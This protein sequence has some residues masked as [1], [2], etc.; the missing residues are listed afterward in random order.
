MGQ[1]MKF[2]PVYFTIVQ[3]RFNPILS[4]DSYAP[5]IQE[6]LRKAGFPDFQKAMK[7]TLNIPAAGLQPDQSVSQGPLSQTLLYVFGDMERTSIFLLEPGALSFQTT[8]YDVFETLLSSFRKGLEAVEEAV[9]LSYTD[10]IGLRYLDAVFPKTGETLRD[11]ICPGLLGLA[12]GFQ[13]DGLTY[14]FS[15]NL[16]RQQG[17]NV[18]LRAIIHDGKVEFP[19]DLLPLTLGLDERFA[20]LQGLHAIMDTDGWFE[21]REKFSLENVLQQLGRIHQEIDKTFRAS[22]T[23]NA[24]KV[25]G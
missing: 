22:V 9:S 21:S 23:E 4:L 5:Q 13:D 25:W 14:A 8:H 15:E 6:K 7:T 10:R 3:A 19:P 18:R 11:Y 20:K 16:T 12:E 17:I 2:A 1:G 24:L